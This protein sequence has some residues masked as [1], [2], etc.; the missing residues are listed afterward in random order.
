MAPSA[1][2]SVSEA[3]PELEFSRAH[4][5]LTLFR[6]GPQV[7]SSSGAPSGSLGARFELDRDLDPLFPFINAVARDAQFFETP[8][9]IKFVFADH[10]CAFYPREGVFSPVKDLGDALAFLPRLISFVADIAK[11]RAQIVPNHRKFKTESALDILRLLPRHNCRACGYSTCVAFAA[12]LSRRLTSPLNCPHLIHPVEEKAVFPVFDAQGDLVRTV[13]LDINS[14]LLRERLHQK[15]RQIHSLQSR[16]RELEQDHSV[17]VAAVNR[18]LPAPLTK[19]EM[20]V[21]R[22]LADGS[23]NK[24][25][26]QALQISGHT[27][28]SHV[29]HIFNKIGVSDRTQ[30]SVW[31]AV[32]GILPAAH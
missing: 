28:K 27:V 6:S 25:I 19:R 8:L 3:S 29:I 22:H 32:H 5:S 7:A 9:Y 17:R 15:E 2:K 30:A 1:N 31:A 16:L 12:A 24:Q 14:N 20:E 4:T 13:C 26:A 11:R 21:L 10:L 18:A 23:T